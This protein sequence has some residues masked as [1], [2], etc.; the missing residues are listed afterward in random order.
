M[1]RVPPVEVA[2]SPRLHPP[3]QPSTV[4]SFLEGGSVNPSKVLLLDLVW[5]SLTVEFKVS[6]KSLRWQRASLNTNPNAF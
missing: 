5:A 1:F 4:G 2:T 3:Q 6:S